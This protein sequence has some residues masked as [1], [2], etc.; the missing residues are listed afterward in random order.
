MEPW[1]PLADQTT[2]DSVVIAGRRLRPGDRVRLRPR[3]RA[4]IFDLVLDGKLARIE[5]IEE[6]FDG[7]VEFSSSPDSD[8]LFR[9][10]FKR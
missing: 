5:S 9:L 4:D 8:S 3:G 6:D 10:Y 2:V 1:N 7:H